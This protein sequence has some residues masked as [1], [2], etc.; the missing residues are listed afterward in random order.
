MMFVTFGV[1]M[2]VFGMTRRESAQSPHD[3]GGREP[4]GG[5][6]QNVMKRDPCRLKFREGLWW[7]RYW[8]IQTCLVKKLWR[9]PFRL[10]EC[11][12]LR[13]ERRGRNWRGGGRSPCPGV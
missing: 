5:A 9:N 4:A 12:N 3:G 10:F 2:N 7:G 1:T 13:S 6:R 11:R 8:W